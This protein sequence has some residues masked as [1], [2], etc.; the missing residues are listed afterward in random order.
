MAGF[1]SWSLLA[2]DRPL[3][4]WRNRPASK[5]FLSGGHGRDAACKQG[6]VL[7]KFNESAARPVGSTRPNAFSSYL[8]HAA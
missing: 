6:K 7:I 1:L 2:I 8:K 4:H 5:W 3:L